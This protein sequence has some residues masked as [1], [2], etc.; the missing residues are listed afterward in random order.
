MGTPH[1]LFGA[2]RTVPAAGDTNWGDNVSGILTDLIKAMNLMATL[3]GDVPYLIMSKDEQT[4]TAGGTVEI[5]DDPAKG[6]NRIVLTAGSAVTLGVSGGAN[7][8]DNG[9]KDGQTLLLVGTSD[10]NT[11]KLDSDHPNIGLNGDIILGLND[12]IFLVWNA[13]VWAEV[14]RSN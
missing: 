7:T 3:V 6:A 4:V 2:T 12:A 8:I 9:T 14:S 13:S 10:T 11:V 1:E 5:S